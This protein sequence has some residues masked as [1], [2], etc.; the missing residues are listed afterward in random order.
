MAGVL[1]Y[2]IWG[3]FPLY[4]KV[5]GAV[6]PLEILAH[7]IVWSFVLLLTLVSFRGML[8]GFINVFR[9]PLLL[10]SLAITTVLITI[11]WGLFIY[12]VSIG[13]TK[14]ASLGY[15]INPF[16]NVALGMVF[17]G[18]R[19]TLL[20]KIALVFAA[21]GVGWLVVQHMQIPWIPLTLGF[22]FGVYGLLRKRSSVKPLLGLTVETA[23]MTPIALGYAFFLF[24]TEALAIGSVGTKETIMLLCAG[25]LTTVPLL[26]FT[27]GAQTIPYSTMGFIQFITPSLHLFC[28]LVVFRETITG[29]ELISF[30]LIWIGLCFFVAQLLVPAEG[31]RQEKALQEG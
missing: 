9:S 1:G 13:Q 28:A 7:R 6:T 10:R 17:L 29:N 2:C 15:Y 22:T 11:N 25:F 16:V 4:F 23:L 24:Q 31:S 5:L 21:L 26:L 19:L 12:A 18:E 3:L 20:Q 30:V 27:F 14:S 8:P